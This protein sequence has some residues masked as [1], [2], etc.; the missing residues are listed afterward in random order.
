[1]KLGQLFD[2]SQLASK[3]ERRQASEPDTSSKPEA[4]HPASEAD[5]GSKPSA[6][7]ASSP[8]NEIFEQLPTCLN[9]DAA[10]GM[11]AVY[12]LNLTGEGECKWHVRIAD[13]KCE[14]GEGEDPAP[15]ITIA[16]GAHD[17]LSLVNGS[18]DPQTAFVGGKIKI[19]G[20]MSLA[21]KLG[22]LFDTSRPD[23]K[24]EADRPASEADSGS[25]P[26]AD[27]ASSPVRE[28]FA[29]LPSRLNKDATGDLKAVYQINLAGGG[30]KWHVK[31]ADGK[32]EVGEGEDPAPNI[33]IAM[34]AQDFLGL[35]NGSLDPQTA[36][37][38][39]KIKIHGD[40]SLALKLGQLFDTSRPD[41]KSEANGTA[42]EQNTGSKINSPSKPVSRPASEDKPSTA[43][44]PS[45]PSPLRYG[46]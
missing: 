11:N 40:M 29:Q 42:R 15:N 31:I 19:N 10:A 17:F 28:I 8:I 1:L 13:G 21:L 45:G 4:N 20:D 24:P 7:S 23:S 9:K 18:L 26:S 12:Q 14:V 36:F 46:R 3:P 27:A 35:V 22:Q 30:G 37:V 25:E 5:S 33:T 32:C 6:D 34:E 16:M 43:A 38:G 2:T 39:G 41:S 44:Q